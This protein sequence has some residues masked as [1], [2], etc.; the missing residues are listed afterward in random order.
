MADPN[1]KEKKACTFSI[2]EK[3]QKEPGK[4]KYYKNSRLF[5]GT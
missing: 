5:S 4:E 1:K 3:M 2:V